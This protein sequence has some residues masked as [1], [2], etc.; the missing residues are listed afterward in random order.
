MILEKAKNSE[1][2]ERDDGENDEICR[3]GIDRKPIKAMED[4]DPDVFIIV[5]RGLD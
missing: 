5:A 1:K 2:V 3:N 4:G